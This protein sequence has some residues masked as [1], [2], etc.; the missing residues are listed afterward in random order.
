[1]EKR[2]LVIIGAGP[3]GLTS[4]IYGR[5][6][7]LD[8]L[9]IEKGVAGGQINITAE[10]ENWPGVVHASGQELGNMFREH[11]EKF[12][13][14][15]R[16][17][18]VQK[19]E[20]RD[21]AKVVVTDKGEIEAEAVIF[22][23]GAYFRRLGCEGEA[24]RIG[25]GVSYC[26]VCDGAFF[27]DQVIA[28]VGG[29]NTAVE[30]A[31]YLT[32]FASKVYIIHR[33]DEFRA[34]RAAIARTLANPK[35]EPIWNSVVEKIEGDGMVENLVL[36]NV[37]TGKIS[38]LPVAG[39]FVFV[40]Q[41]PH[42]ECIRGLVEAKK[43]GWIVTND[44][45]ETS[46][47]GIFAAGDVRDKG[48]RQVVTAAA[49]GAVAAMTASAYINEQVHLRS[50]LLDPERVVAFFYSSIDEAQV[51]LSNEVEEMSKKTGKKVALIDGYRNARMVGKL[52]LEKMPVVVELKKGV[53]ASKKVVSSVSEISELLK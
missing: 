47:E 10:I 25:A 11:A 44:N 53:V 21:G 35:I 34:D 8:V 46:V 28:V 49:D 30:E 36:K 38:D 31:N 1:M 14:E 7:G 50:T 15:F 37:K 18:E 24:E 3:A 5:R 42:D 52:A 27:E 17:A 45:M 6:A 43:G 48:L 4:A 29:G 13:T 22:A 40:G 19:I 2:E 16:D 32:T 51:R 23:T 9:L 41:A 26:A 20:V 39:V 12:N 33:R